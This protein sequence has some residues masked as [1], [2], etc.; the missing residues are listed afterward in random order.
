M[1]KRPN[2]NFKTRELKFK[3]L[4]VCEG[5]TEKNYFN[6]MKEDLRLPKTI[7]VDVFQSNKVDCKGVVEEAL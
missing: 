1:A 4:I 6:A 5:L 2:N 7:G 3:T